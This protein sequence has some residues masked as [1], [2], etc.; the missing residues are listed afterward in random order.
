[1]GGGDGT[2]SVF[3]PL[4]PPTVLDSLDH[5]WQLVGAVTSMSPI[6]DSD[7]LVACTADGRKYLVPRTRAR[8]V[9]SRCVWRSRRRPRDQRLFRASRRGLRPRG[10]GED[11]ERARRGDAGDDLGVLRR[12]P[13]RL[14]ADA[15]A[16]ADDARHRQERARS[17]SASR[18]RRR[19]AFVSGWGD[20]HIRCHD[21][22]TGALLWTLPDA[23][24]GGVSAIAVANGQHF[25]VSGGE[26]GEVRVWDMRTRGMIST[27]KEHSGG[28]VVGVAVLRD[29]VH[30][31]S[32]SRDPGIITWDLI[33]ER[34]VS[35]H[36]QRVPGINAFELSQGERDVQMVS[37]G[38][39]PEP[40]L[41]G[42]DGGAAAADRARRARARCT[43]VALRTRASWPPG[44]RTRR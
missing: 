17:P 23:H 1:M 42:P 18:R 34:R 39:D 24:T 2:V 22:A 30:V 37:V 38:Q 3:N 10:G 27:L 6:A 33:R 15:S 12:A 20:G 31:V 25:F 21:N 19:K 8:A 26:G 5:V 28:R 43:C 7:D 13:S 16:G 9:A 41:L 4:K 36:Q 40:L 11:Q 44:A 14:D 35:Q 29:D 32:A